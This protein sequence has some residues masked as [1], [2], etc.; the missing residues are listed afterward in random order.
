MKLHNYLLEYMQMLTLNTNTYDLLTSIQYI[1]HCTDMNRY[2]RITN[3][4]EN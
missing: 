4:M 3:T 2:E 1:S